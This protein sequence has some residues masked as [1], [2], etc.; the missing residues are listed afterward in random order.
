M[1]NYITTKIMTKQQLVN[2]LVYETEKIFADLIVTK[3]DTQ[4]TEAYKKGLI[5]PSELIT[6]SKLKSL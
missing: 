3:E 4:Y 6:N 1:V 2:R 5:T